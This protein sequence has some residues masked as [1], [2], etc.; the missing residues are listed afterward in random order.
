MA[1]EQNLEQP[2]EQANEP[3]APEVKADPFESKALEMTRLARN[4]GIFIVPI[5]PP[6][7][8]H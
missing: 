5:L 4:E 3:A 8:L 1:D 2:N 7:V 6:A